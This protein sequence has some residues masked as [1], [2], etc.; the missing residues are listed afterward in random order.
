MEQ[1]YKDFDAYK[2]ASTT[3]AFLALSNQMSEMY[4]EWGTFDV[5]CF[6]DSERALINSAVMA[7]RVA[8]MRANFLVI[9]DSI[10]QRFISKEEGM[11]MIY[12]NAM[13]C[14][15][16]FSTMWVTEEKIGDHCIEMD[17]VFK[18]ILDSNECHVRQIIITKQDEE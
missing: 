9:L 16:V 15:D 6:D 2:T 4:K 8:V 1:K 5:Q 11:E 12:K 10:K 14:P 3:G 13:R 18:A 7:F 17:S